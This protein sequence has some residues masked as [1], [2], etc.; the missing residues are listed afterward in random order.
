[1][2]IWES[3]LNCLVPASTKA[4]VTWQFFPFNSLWYCGRISREEKAK[5]THA[6]LFCS[7]QHTFQF[8]ADLA[9]S[10]LLFSFKAPW[11]T[12]QLKLTCNTWI[13]KS[14][15]L[16]TFRGYKRTDINMSPLSMSLWVRVGDLN[17]FLLLYFGFLLIHKQQSMTMWHSYV[18]KLPNPTLIQ[19]IL[20]MHIIKGRTAPVKE[21]LELIPPLQ[22]LNYSVACR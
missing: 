18:W 6:Y 1:M 10:W 12:L 20:Q 13:L 11:K 22:T 8:K 3:A 9:A 17:I 2:R 16:S 5:F 15:W 14:L 21:R 7:V 4:W 19:Q